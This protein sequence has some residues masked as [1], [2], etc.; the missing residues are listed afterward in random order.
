MAAFMLNLVVLL[1]YFIEIR[2]KDQLLKMNFFVLLG[3]E[4]WGKHFHQCAGKHQ[5]PIDIDS[6]FVTMVALSPLEMQGFNTT[7]GRALLTNNGHTGKKYF[8]F[9]EHHHETTTYASTLL[10]MMKIDGNIKPTISGGPLNAV[11]EFAQLHFHWGQND[12]C[13]SENK[14]DKK[15]FPLELHIVF[16]KKEYLNVDSALNYSDGLTVLACIF[17]VM[18]KYF[19][20]VVFLCQI[21]LQLADKPNPKYDSF[22]Q[23]LSQVTTPGLIAVFPKAPTLYDL[24]PNDLS[25]YFTYHGSLTTPPC[26]EAVTWID[27]R[28]TIKIKSTQVNEANNFMKKRI[29][30]KRSVFLCTSTN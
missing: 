30:G 18:I 27:F 4:S 9:I 6:C 13:G 28:E 12:T 10:A 24:L 21:F 17:E 2:S 14:F 1:V 22:V 19:S 5:S 23:L 11:Y 7:V 3:Q 29:T 25:Q 20:L 15:Q 16:Y 26:S 8:N